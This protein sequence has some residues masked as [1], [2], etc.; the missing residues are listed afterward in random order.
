MSYLSDELRRVLP[1]DLNIAYLAEDIDTLEARIAELEA[2]VP[3]W[4]DSPKV[5]TNVWHVC[6]VDFT[7]SPPRCLVIPL[8][9]PAPP[10]QFNTLTEDKTHDREI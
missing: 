8:P 7:T 3:R 10:A 6:E 9:L 2:M 5:G 1:Y 4:M